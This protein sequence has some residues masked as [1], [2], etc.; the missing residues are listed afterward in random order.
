MG[1]GNEPRRHIAIGFPSDFSDFSHR[2]KKR[3]PELP[4]FPCE[5]PTLPLMPQP[6]MLQEPQQELQVRTPMRLEQPVL[7]PLPQQPSLQT[8]RPGRSLPRVRLTC[9]CR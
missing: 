8:H 5:L 6:S 3:Q 2:H 4:F 7:P 1:T 9:G